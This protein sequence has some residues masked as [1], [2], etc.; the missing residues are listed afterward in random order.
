[1]SNVKKNPP[2]RLNPNLV[3]RERRW[4]LDADYVDSLDPDD[5]KYLAQF[6]DEYYRADYRYAEPMHDTPELQSER[7][8]MQN[9]NHRDTYALKQASGEL[10]YG[11]PVDRR[12]ADTLDLIPS[13]HYLNGEEYK[14]AVVELRKLVD[15]REHA[16]T[17][18][19][20][21]RIE[22]LQMYLLSIREAE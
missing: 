9:A 20:L 15:V 4:M 6:L 21:A 11:I 14:S 17:P 22:T 8:G 1:M 19:Q 5:A 12:K 2:T 18:R 10:F 7:Y 16:R 3:P 13:P